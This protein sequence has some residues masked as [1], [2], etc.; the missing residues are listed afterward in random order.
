[1]TCSALV[2]ADTQFARALSQIAALP[3]TPAT[4]REQ[5]KLQV[6][7]I[8][9]LMHI[10]GY[11]ALAAAEQA[12]LL[13]EQAEALGEPP[14]DPLLLFSVLY[15]FFGANVVAFNGDACRNPLAAQFLSLAEKQGATVPLMVGHELMGSSLLITGEIAEG[16]AYLDREIALYDPAEHSPLMMRFGG[17]M[18]GIYAFDHGPSGYL[19]ILR[20]RWRA[21]RMQE[22]A[23]DWPSWL[24]DAGARHFSVPPDPLRRLF[25]GKV[26][27]G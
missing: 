6:A 4:R 13:I 3:P 8:T 5:I 25:S 22:G 24:F 20:P 23:R 17:G 10:K 11:A 12:R 7:R 15:G 26:S 19:A 14:E 18:M 27:I 21:H 2:E 16:R 1:M 9:T